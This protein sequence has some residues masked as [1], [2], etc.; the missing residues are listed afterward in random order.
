MAHLQRRL[1]RAEGALAGLGL[2]RR[3]VRALSRELLAERSR[4]KAMEEELEGPL[5]VHR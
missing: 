2:L 1:A 3:E 4:V 5:N